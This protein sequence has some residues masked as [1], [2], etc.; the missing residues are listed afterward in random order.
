MRPAIDRG[1]CVHSGRVAASCIACLA[2][3]PRSAV[4]L[5]GGAPEISEHDCD[6]CGLCAA[7]CPR[8]AI[9]LPLLFAR[10]EISGHAACFA[11]CEKVVEG[12]KDGHLIC[13]HAIGLDVLLR[14]MAS[15]TRL[16]LVA[17]GDCGTCDRGHG[18]G[19]LETVA[20]LNEALR[21]RGDA[22]IL[23]KETDARRW[24]LACA[25]RVA[26]EAGRRRFLGTYAAA[27]APEL[28]ELWHGEARRACFTGDGPM[29][30]AIA[31]D[32]ERCVA[33]HACARVCPDGAIHFE[34]AVPAYVLE[35]S[36]CGGC[37]LCVDVCDRG[38][39]RLSAW[40]SPGQPVL[41]LRASSCPS[42]G[43]TFHTIEGNA[44]E[45]C[46]VCAARA[47]RIRPDRVWE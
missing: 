43:T 21:A 35:H 27:A 34:E 32:Q 29:P 15:G 33:C 28:A 4:S 25:S 5:N 14:V 37:G 6:G 38:A 12:A 46:P 11:A 41:P 18:V 26:P 20:R 30:Y 8:D 22:G 17:H 31:L 45:Y 2:I 39:I 1:R 24:S 42:C 23:F 44:K 40:T 10:G 9:T 19:L 47:R 16:W 3:C 7:V 36:A 13:L